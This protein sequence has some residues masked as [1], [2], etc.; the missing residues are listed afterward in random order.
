M[1]SQFH[2]ESGQLTLILG[3]MFSGKTTKLLHELTTLADIGLSVLYVNHSDDQRDTAGSDQNVTTHHTL[4]SEMSDRV[5]TVS[6]SKLSSL[7]VENY[8]VIGIDEGQF[9]SG[10]DQL[11]G[12]P[13]TDL[14]VQVRK[15]VIGDNKIVFVASL[16][17]DF[18]IRSFGPTKELL[19]LASN[20]IMLTA[21]CMNC[22]Q[23]T[24][25]YRRL[26]MV[27]APFTWKIAGTN[28]DQ[29]EVGGADK[30]E[31][32]CLKCYKEKA[33]L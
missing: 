23:Q 4:F 13:S 11:F 12:E 26:V 31:A 32:L 25:P 9:F 21:K 22:L 19:C 6:A 29:K 5:D 30:Y 24:S 15:W 17:G 27:E 16:N 10:R 28:S 1:S 7:S 33:G 8:D 3:A 2:P 18:R 14:E 20:V